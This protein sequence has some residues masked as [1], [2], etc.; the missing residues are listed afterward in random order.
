MLPQQPEDELVLSEVHTKLDYALTFL[1]REIGYSLL[2]DAKPRRGGGVRLCG[3]PP[4]HARPDRSPRGPPAEDGDVS[5]ADAEVAV[6][7]DPDTREVIRFRSETA[8]YAH[9]PDDLVL[10]WRFATILGELSPRALE[11]VRHD[12]LFKTV[13][14]GVRLM[15]LCDYNYSDVVV[16]LAYASVYF[17]GVFEACGDKMSEHEAAHVSVLLIYLAHSFVLD[18]T[19]PLRCWQSHIFRK[20]CTVKVLDAALY[21]LFMMRE[22][23]LRISTEEEQ[24]ALSVLLCPSPKLDVILSRPDRRRAG[25]S[26]LTYSP[27]PAPIAQL[28]RESDTGVRKASMPMASKNEQSTLP[29]REVVQCKA[30]GIAVTAKSASPVKTPALAAA[31]SPQVVQCQATGIAVTAKSASPVKTPA[32]AAACNPLAPTR[33]TS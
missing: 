5:D 16:T 11:K 4:P 3:Q 9:F 32:L 21:R 7:E 19:C 27:A 26:G 29:S 17:K 25:G 28:P 30:T 2:A 13:L 23:A 31:C 20:Y 1:Q 10:V 24:Y 15:H 33:S 6:K 22:F 18:E 12:Q 8:K 14:Q